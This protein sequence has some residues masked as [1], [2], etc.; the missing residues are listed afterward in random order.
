MYNCPKTAEH[1]ELEVVGAFTGMHITGHEKFYRVRYCSHCAAYYFYVSME[2]TVSYGKNYFAFYI[3]LTEDEARQ[4]L[5]VMEKE[6]DDDQIERYLN[7]F[8]WNNQ[9]RWVE[10]P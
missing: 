2:A 9:E 6:E 5:S 3:E 1:G 8:D 4:M 7:D 10:R